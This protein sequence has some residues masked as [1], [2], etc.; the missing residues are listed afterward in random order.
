MK[1]IIIP[2]IGTLLFAYNNSDFPYSELKTKRFQNSKDYIDE[3]KIN[4]N[5][6][7]VYQGFNQ[8]KRYR[9]LMNQTFN[10]KILFKPLIK[11]LSNIDIVYMHPR[12][13]TTLLFPNSIKIISAFSSEQMNFLKFS[14]NLLMIKP[15]ANDG[16]GNLIITAYD[17]KTHQNKI[18][19]FIIKPF[20]PENL[21]IDTIYGYYTAPSGAFL[22]LNVKYVENI[23][24]TPIEVINKI[25]NL[26]GEKKF[27]KIFA[28]NG[29]IF[30]LTINHIPVYIKRD[31]LQGNIYAFKKKFIVKIGSL[32]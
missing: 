4:I 32:R 14:K 24:L 21:K 15:L 10:P 30:A 31:D 11:P 16:V 23:N 27:N 20:F 1:K 17:S 25:V 9:S 13:I 22:S 8:L 28:K 3:F 19:N 12:F 5:P 26:W 29:S 6:N 2:L 18:F 7:A